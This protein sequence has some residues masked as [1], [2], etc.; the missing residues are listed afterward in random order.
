VFVDGR[1]VA[2]AGASGTRKTNALPLVIGG[3]VDAQGRGRE[4]FRGRIDDVRISRGARYAAPFAPARDAP[5]DADTL[6]LLS[7][8]GT[9]GPWVEDASERAA[10]AELRGGARVNER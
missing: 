7:M 10:H 6:L 1:E 5:P 3:D 8:Q 2:A 4:L 9:L